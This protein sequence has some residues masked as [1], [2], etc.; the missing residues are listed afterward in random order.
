M[1]TQRGLHRDPNLI[2]LLGEKHEAYGRRRVVE[3]RCGVDPAGARGVG[4]GAGVE[5]VGRR[6]GVNGVL[7]T[8]ATASIR[9]A[10]AM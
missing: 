5:G 8:C 4:E 6:S 7:P 9:R 10:R 1:T 2:L 3:V